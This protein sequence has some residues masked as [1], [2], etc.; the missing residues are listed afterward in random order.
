MSCPTGGGT[1]GL[2]CAL[3]TLSPS[4]PT[5]SS[6]LRPH[7]LLYLGDIFTL[8]E[9]SLRPE[10]A[11]PLVTPKC[12][13]RGTGLEAWCGYPVSSGEGSSQGTV[14]RGTETALA[15]GMCCGLRMGCWAAQGTGCSFPQSV[16]CPLADGPCVPVPPPESHPGT[17]TA[18][19]AG[20]TGFPPPEEL[21]L[22]KQWWGHVSVG[23]GAFECVWRGTG[24]C[25]VGHV[26]VEVKPCECSEG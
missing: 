10:N 25:E 12:I 15:P 19:A 8:S 2:P 1:W 6:G 3:V 13:V 26:S 22:P 7:C 16:F 20:S 11:I 4:P 24:P 5:A 21:Y 9:G 14:H 23:T 17:E 18:S